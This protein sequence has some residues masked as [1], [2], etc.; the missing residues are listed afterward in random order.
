MIAIL[1]YHMRS[2]WV[3]RVGTTLSVLSIGV[4]VGILVLVLALARGFEMSLTDTGSDENLIVLRQGASSEGESGMTREKWR[5]LRSYDGVA[6]D[7]DGEPLASAEVYAA[8]NLEKTGGGTANFPLRGVMPASF[9]VRSSARIV[10]G[11]EFLPGTTEIVVGRALLGRLRGCSLGGAIEAGGRS[12]P[13]VGVI[14]SGG[15][16]YDSEIWCDVEVFLQVFRRTIYGEIVVRRATP[17]PAE[18]PDPFVTA[19]EKDRRLDAKLEGER[20]YFRS[21]SGVLGTALK[22]VAGFIAGVMSVGA[23]FATAVTL[24]ASVSERRREIG[25]LLAIGFRPWHVVTG[26]LAEAAVLGLAGGAVGVLLALPVNGVATGTMNWQTFTEQAFAFRITADVVV[27][28]VVF[29][30]TV[31]LLAGFVPAHRASRVPPSEAL[32]G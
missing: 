2:L 17:A 3:R 27:S 6:L 12:W 4:A 32:R 19:I 22:W 13:V 25:T 7:A 15:G 5:I 26:F 1:R 24:L 11:R 18:G 23:A 20:S 14:D 31:G 9:R 16:A 8:M 21:Q 29:A 10:A 30:T 28:A